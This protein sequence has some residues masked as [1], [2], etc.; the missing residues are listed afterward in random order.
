MIVGKVSW[1][2]YTLDD[3]SNLVFDTNV[4]NLAYLS[5]DTFRAE[6]IEYLSKTVL[7]TLPVL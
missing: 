3:P 5:P 4:T 1:P 6:A 2:K 7:T